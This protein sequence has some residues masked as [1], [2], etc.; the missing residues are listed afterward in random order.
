TYDGT[1]SYAS[2]STNGGTVWGNHPSSDLAFRFLVSAP[3]TATPTITNSPTPTRTP[4]ATFSPTSTP[5]PPAPNLSGISPGN[6]STSGG[7]A[8]TLFGTNLSG[9]AT[10]TFNGAAVTITNQTASQLVVTAP[11]GGGAL[12]PVIAVVNGQ[13]SNVVDFAYDPPTL[14]ALLPANGSSLGG[15][16]VTLQG[17]DF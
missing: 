10:V 17:S 6:G 11:S 1:F 3:P 14:T 16:P 5:T 4:T 13:S 15:Y 8:V 2:T 7:Y 12:V 9:P